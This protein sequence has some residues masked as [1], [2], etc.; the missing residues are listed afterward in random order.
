MKE[1][2]F[3]IMLALTSVLGI[4]LT[5]FLVYKA[6]KLPSIYSPKG[7]ESVSTSSAIIEEGSPS[8]LPTVL[9]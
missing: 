4:A 1:R 3:Y 9:K 2:G 6:A 5:A 7:K 8:T